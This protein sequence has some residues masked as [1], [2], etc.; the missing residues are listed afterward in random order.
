[1]KSQF[2]NVYWHKCTGK[3]MAK[4]NF[5]HVQNHLGIFTSEH[6]ASDAVTAFK[7]KNAIEI[8]PNADILT[9]VKYLSGYLVWR[10]NGAQHLMGDVVGSA[11][12]SSGY[13]TLRQGS[14]KLYLHRLVWQLLNGEIPAD[15]QIDH[16]DGNRSNNSIE[17][18]RLVTRTGNM[19]NT[20]LRFTNKTGVPGVSKLST[21]RYRALV[22]DGG[23]TVRLGH[24]HSLE[25]ATA[26]RTEAAKTLGYHANHGR[27]T[28]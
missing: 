16:I 20:K 22:Q 15:M 6:D 1:M 5:N 28:S 10:E 18:L 23:K 26:A 11:V 4:V 25:A 17:N 2:R 9:R 7:V 27:K 19:K 3:W 8:D 13:V 14:K 24:F 21:G 12:G